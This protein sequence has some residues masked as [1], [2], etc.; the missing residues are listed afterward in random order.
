MAKKKAQKSKGKEQKK[1]EKVTSKPKGKGVY[2]AASVII[3]ICIIGFLLLT[4]SSGEES[5]AQITDISGSV[6]VKHEGSWVTAENGMDLYQSDFVKTG[7]NSSASLILFK[8]SII[9][10]ASNTEV[11]LKEVLEVAGETSVTLQQDAGRTWNTIAKMS[12]ID[13]YEVQTPTS[14]AS[15][16]GTSFDVYIH[17][18]GNVTISVVNG[19]VNVTDIDEIIFTIEVLENLS[20]TIDPD[21]MDEPPSL[22]PFVKDDWILDNLLKD[23]TFRDALKDEL[24]GKISPY[25]PEIRETYGINITD[26]EIDI[27]IDAYIHGKFDLPSGL[28]ESVIEEIFG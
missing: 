6:Q 2:L 13:N 16:R 27:L 25:I 3:I 14:V 12:G 4:S 28:P 21:Q 18:D 11:T 24:Y 9:R 26:E 8:S 5:K 7:D 19:T 20:V 1:T 17:A 10:L 15:V 22:E 23:E